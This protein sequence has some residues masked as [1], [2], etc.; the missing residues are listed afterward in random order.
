MTSPTHRRGERGIAFL[1][2]IALLVP[3][4][5][6]ASFVIDAGRSYLVKTSLAK[7]LDA[8]A[9]AGAQA[10]ADGDA[11]AQARIANI[12]AAN[13][14]AGHLGFTP[15]PPT[16]AFATQ[17]DGS[18]TIRVSE[19][20]AVR[21][22]FAQVVGAG[23]WTV[24]A[25]AEVT[26]RLVDVAF[27]VD[28]SGSLDSVW[29]QVQAASMQFVKYFDPARDRF[30]LVVFSG[31]TTVMQPMSASRGFDRQG[32]LDALDGLRSGGSTSTAEG[33]YHGWDQL[34]SVPSG[35]QSGSRII[36]LFTDGAPNGVPGQFRVTVTDRGGDHT[37]IANGTVTT[38]DF[39]QVSASANTTNSPTVSGVYAT[40]GTPARPYDVKPAVSFTG[41]GLGTW[42]AEMPYLP[43][44][45]YHP[46]PV[47]AGIPTGFQ[48][49]DPAV[50]GQRALVGFDENGYPANV[51]NANNAARNLAET[52]A[53]YA[54]ND[55]S[56]A[57]RIR[58]FT[59]G[60]GSL[61]NEAMG[62]GRE[63]G[64]SILQRIANDP[65]SADFSTGEPEGRYFYAADASELAAAFEAVRNQIIRISE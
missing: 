32:V 9:L 12:F 62:T 11:A 27:V 13:F 61:L 6:L 10:L 33:L 21:T 43:T 23:S 17:A 41:G 29:S 2:L 5:M 26:R 42:P 47:S 36:V 3:L 48:L 52:V 39:P 28:K 31:T 35:S 15:P 4:L 40:D 58:I 53:Y 44:T 19:S 25:Q 59:L 18:R 60:L 20:M 63:T 54:R 65:H 7:A 56:G 64:A 57:S 38:R 30:S 45:S 51:G 46:T 14:P 55:G 22:G 1:V 50:P 16:V 24:G 49:F 37:T 8:A 34:R